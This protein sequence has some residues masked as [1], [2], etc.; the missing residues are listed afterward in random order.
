MDSSDLLPYVDYEWTTLIY[1]LMWTMSGLLW[2][3]T[4]CG[5]WVDYS[6]ILPYVDSEWTSLIYY[7]MWTMNGL[8][9]YITLC[10]LWMDFSDILPNVDYDIWVDFSYILPYVDYEWTPLIHWYEWEEHDVDREHCCPAL[11]KIRLLYLTCILYFIPLI[12]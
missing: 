8:L 4:L 5:Q 6:D 1:Y 11:N 3:I 9:W 2:Y 7:L 10:G 12:Q